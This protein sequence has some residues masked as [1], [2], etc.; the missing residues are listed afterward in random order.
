M[1]GLIARPKNPEG[2]GGGAPILDLMG[3]IVV[4]VTKKFHFK[5]NFYD[6]IFRKF[7]KWNLLDV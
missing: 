4:A 3:T 1:N 5:G 6:S 7:S 2:G